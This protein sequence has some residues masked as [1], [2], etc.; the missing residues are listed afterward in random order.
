MGDRGKARGHD[1]APRC[2][3]L[4]HQLFGRS[5]PGADGISYKNGHE[6]QALGKNPARMLSR[7]PP[8]YLYVQSSPVASEFSANFRDQTQTRFATAYWLC[9]GP[10][11]VKKR[12]VIC[13]KKFRTGEIH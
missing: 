6:D 3:A 5:K 4:P 11:F 8:N 2:F 12:L 13:R 10:P 9:Y 1:L 7:Q